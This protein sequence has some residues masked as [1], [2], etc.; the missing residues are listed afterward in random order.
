MLCGKE[1]FF[2]LTRSPSTWLR[3]AWARREHGEN[4][5]VWSDS[6]R[7]RIRPSISP[8]RDIWLN[9]DPIE[10]LKWY[11]FPAPAGWQI[12]LNSPLRNSDQIGSGNSV[13]SVRGEKT[14]LGVVVN[15]ITSPQRW[16][17]R[18]RHGYGSLKIQLAPSWLTSHSET[19][20]QNIPIVRYS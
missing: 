9:P 11:W 4:N 1:D 15:W 7:G 5:Y 19:D 16:S 14:L 13:R 2:S 8:L 3:A 12:D 17:G 18:L 6:L 20:I 10:R